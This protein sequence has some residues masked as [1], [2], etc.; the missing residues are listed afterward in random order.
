ME[1]GLKSMVTLAVKLLRGEEVL[2]ERDGYIA[3]GR[4]KNYFADKSGAVRAVDMLL[5]KL[6]GKPFTTDYAMPVFDRVP[7][8]APVLDM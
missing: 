6:A 2:P 1:E 7:P 4:R 8:A 5:L 3:Q